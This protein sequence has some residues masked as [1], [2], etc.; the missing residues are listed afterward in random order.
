MLAL[1]NCCCIKGI[2]HYGMLWYTIFK[3]SHQHS[4][5]LLYSR[6]FQ[7]HFDTQ[8]TSKYALTRVYENMSAEMVGAAESCTAVLTDVRF[9]AG[10]HRPSVRIQHQRLEKSGEH[11]SATCMAQITR[12]TQTTAGTRDPLYFKRLQAFLC[13]EISM[14]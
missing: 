3:A 4:L 5:A 10:R 11:L 6:S 7:F 14:Y 12:Q 1:R 13:L 2:K 9:G 8:P